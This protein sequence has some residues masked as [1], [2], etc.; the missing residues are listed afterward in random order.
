MVP[1]VRFGGHAIPGDSPL[2]ADGDALGTGTAID[3]LDAGGAL[4]EG[5]A[6]LVADL[7]AQPTTA[8]FFLVDDDHFWLPS[9]ESD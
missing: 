4:Y 9:F 2:R 6:V 1:V 7:D 3:V 5:H 8:T